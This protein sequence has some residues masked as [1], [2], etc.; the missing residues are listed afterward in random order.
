MKRFILCLPLT[1]ALLGCPSAITAPPAP[2]APG[3]LSPDDEKWGQALAAARALDY[4]ATLDYQRL[5]AAQQ[6]QEK[7][8]LNNFTMAVNTADALYQAYHVG[9]A[10]PAQ[11][12]AAVAQ[13]QTAQTAYSNVAVK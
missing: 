11:V 3:Y 4:Q 10:T 12:S 6:A 13:V 9:Q 2:T 7:G 5:P 1:L 8:A